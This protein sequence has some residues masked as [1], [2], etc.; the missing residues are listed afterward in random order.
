[1]HSSISQNTLHTEVHLQPGLGQSAARH[2]NNLFITGVHTLAD[3]FNVRRNMLDDTAATSIDGS[4]RGGGAGAIIDENSIQI[5]NDP[6]D[7]ALD[8]EEVQML[9]VMSRLDSQRQHF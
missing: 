4:H 7:Q 8:E 9:N 1:M 6:N 2:G 5:N 3:Y